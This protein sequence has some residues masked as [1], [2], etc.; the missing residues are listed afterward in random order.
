MLIHLAS[1]KKVK[2]HGLIYCI[3]NISSILI[4]TIFYK[5]F[6]IYDDEKENDPFLYWL[7]FS[8]ITQTTVG[9]AGLDLELSN[10]KYC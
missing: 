3:A 5:I 4:F 9:Y 6:D 7:Y 8:S 10:N 2:N 1:L